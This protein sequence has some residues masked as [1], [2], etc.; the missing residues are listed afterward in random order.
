[1]ATN[2]LLVRIISKGEQK[3]DN[4]GHKMD[5]LSAKAALY[6]KQTTHALDQNNIKWKKHFDSVDKMV[7]GTGKMIGK[8]VGMSAKFAA[9]QVA[10]LGAA[11]MAVH[12]AFVLG[13]AS[14]KAFQW[15]AKG[16]A[17]AA[18]AVGV[19][20]STA[21]AA[22][23]EQQQSMFA[24]QGG[25]NYQQVS[26]TMRSLMNDTNLAA[27]GAE[28]LQGAFA[29]ISK[30]STFTAASQNLLKGLG[31]FAA[32]GQ[33][34]EQGMKA[35]G[36]L[37]AA[38]QDPKASFSKVTEAAK[39][40]GPQMTK[41]LETAKKK[42]IDTVE[43][44]KAAINSGELASMGGVSGQLAAVNDT[45]L[46]RFKASFASIKTMF[47]DIGGPFL[48]PAK[49]TLDKLVSI[50][51]RTV[52]QLSGDIT[53]F[54]G[55]QGLF[56]KIVSMVDRAAQFF[57]NF[58]HKWGPQSEGI[59]SRMSGWWGK[60][61]DGWDMV[62]NKLRPL[63]DGARVLE[64]AIG[65]IFRPIGQMF[66][67]SF[68]HMNDL[69]T[70]NKDDF[71]QFGTAIGNF[72]TVFMKYAGSV[73][74]TFVD[75]LPFINKIIDGVT[76]IFD[77][78]TSLI[79]GIKGMFGGGGF[80]SFAVIAGLLSAKRSMSKH[81]G[82]VMPSTKLMAVKADNVTITGFT[83][84]GQATSGGQTALQQQRAANKARRQAA[85]GQSA[86]GGVGGV[87]GAAGVTSAGGLLGPN[88]MPITSAGMASA[89]SKQLNSIGRATQGMTSE[90]KL[91]AHAA[92]SEAKR[93][94]RA[95]GGAGGAASNQ[96]ISYD[97]YKKL[98]YLERAVP[99]SPIPQRVKNN[100]FNRATIATPQNVGAPGGY[101]TGT[102]KDRLSQ[103]TNMLR[104]ARDT[105]TYKRIFGGEHGK[106]G[107]AG[108]KNFKGINNK[109]STAMGASAALGLLSSV[110]P[111]AA[112]GAIALGS[113]ISMVNPVAGLAVGLIG[114]AITGF[115]GA[116]KKRKKEA[117][118]AA[119]K[120]AE[121]VM[122]DTIGGMI[123]SIGRMKRSGTFTE[124]KRRQA[125]SVTADK[126]KQDVFDA[127][128][129]SRVRAAAMS[130][131]GVAEDK[132]T[133]KKSMIG[134]GFT[135]L[136][137]I[138]AVV[139]A[140]AAGSKA[141]K[142]LLEE[143]YKAQTGFAKG[144]TEDEYNKAKGN[145]NEFFKTLEENTQRNSDAFNFIQE[146]S[147]K[148]VD[149]FSKIF[150][151][152]TDKI[153]EMAEAVGENLYDAT[154]KSIDQIKKMAEAMINTRR[155][156]MASAANRAGEL[157]T[158]YFTSKINAM[159]AE[160][161]LD[162]NAF[163]LRDKFDAGALG[164]QDVLQ[165]LQDQQTALT[166]FYGGDS[167]KA[168]AEF[169]KMFGKGGTAFSQLNGPLEG[170]ESTLNFLAT[171]KDGNNSLQ[172]YVTESRTGATSDL[173]ELV[174]SNLLM[175]G[176]QSSTTDAAGLNA[177]LST[178]NDQQRMRI[179]T[180]ATQDMTVQ[181]NRQALIDALYK[182]TTDGNNE[183]F[184]KLSP[185]ADPMKDAAT[186]LA[187]ASE[188]FKASVDVLI[189]QLK[190]GDTRT[191][192]GHIGDS[193]MSNL[194][195]TLSSHNSV[196]SRLAGKRSITSSYRN[197]ALGSLKSDHVTGRALDITGQNLVSYRDSMN[198][199]GGF[200]EFHGA[201]D[202][203]HL[204][205]VPPQ[206]GNAIGDSYTAVGAAGSQGDSSGLGN[207]TNN[208]SFNISG[209]NA[210]DIANVVMRKIAAT[211]KS[212]A[213]RR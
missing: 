196:N 30:T 211:G 28:A 49:E 59:F 150:G 192:R 9:L 141:Q 3:L 133:G 205:V 39:A 6:G 17:G 183:I 194:G 33:P 184:M 182:M 120:V 153:N 44:L 81:I 11:M 162:V 96:L 121:D 201:G 74:E 187:S 52:I 41:A 112:Q 15:V 19:A 60:F 5:K 161:Q 209:T 48:K 170:M 140:A 50:F 93:A 142:A 190:A 158:K 210:E 2:N 129:G 145:I 188:A 63:I 27:A 26:V 197:Y 108:Y 31:D 46:N 51:K 128:A 155:E 131:F 84:R 206:G 18:L 22:M 38:L 75:A 124:A 146:T 176:F 45:L 57:V 203:R 88:G 118:M 94:S 152:S 103:K 198:G 204:H 62:L 156:L 213:E 24:F 111:E 90:Q 37:V 171:D 164:Q 135:E 13:N 70:K 157:S 195:N 7:V 87:P 86:V 14:M 181:E 21:A 159:E 126:M 16:A 80:G 40:M 178:L 207:I 165:F 202:T 179:E 54:G 32:A 147:V 102:L 143:M 83:D 98:P 160:K 1:M 43:E 64:Q 78:F 144:M 65:N 169:A 97:E 92:R 154:A 134:D 69:I 127:Q 91:A 23:R 130:K 177:G 105:V 137:P 72:I 71:L 20:I 191:P 168:N 172:G 25:K 199:S 101:G 119:S 106:V 132:S 139:T 138:G 67:D 117:R 149:R 122:K 173:A 151:V 95:F 56:D 174:T 148:K 76:K 167:I 104:Q 77:I 193:T 185:I 125:M 42:G 55:N 34:L 73:R 89:R 36:D 186:S 109:A 115:I 85:M 58:V 166:S 180:L 4:I 212:N 116:A 123:D 189:E 100:R 53:A 47:A 10:A 82:G 136:A 163:G 12:G 35:A 114:G 113:A 99:G 107:T 110:A 175:G 68:G 66:A 8:F 79:G 61:R 208:Y 29:S 200:A